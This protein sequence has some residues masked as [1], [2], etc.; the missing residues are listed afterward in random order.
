MFM[1]F[2]RDGVAVLAFAFLSAALGVLIGNAIVA[3]RRYAR[4][5]KRTVDAD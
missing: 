4:Q 1:M 5:I 2:L 3:F